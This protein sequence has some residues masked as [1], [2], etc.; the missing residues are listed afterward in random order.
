MGNVGVG[1]GMAVLVGAVVGRGVAVSAGRGES[2]G[3]G[4][5]ASVA[6]GAGRGVATGW[7]ATRVEVAVAGGVAVSSGVAVGTIED[8]PGAVGGSVKPAVRP[9]EMS[10]LP[11]RGFVSPYTTDTDTSPA[12]TMVSAM[13]TNLWTI[14]NTERLR[15]PCGKPAP[16]RV[17][18]TPD[19]N[20]LHRSEMSTNDGQPGDLEPAKPARR[21]ARLAAASN[22]MTGATLCHE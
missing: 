16:C 15:P 13:P 20:R 19:L 14:E 22:P 10:G 2:V 12:A 17:D 11:A 5:G 6:V 1:N 8:C 21:P 7:A 9:S 3:G 18:V 4:G